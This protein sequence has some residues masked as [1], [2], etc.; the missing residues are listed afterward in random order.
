M[1]EHVLTIGLIG[2]GAFAQSQDMPNFTRHPQLKTKWCCDVNI[3]R[4]K[5]MA[6]EFLVPHATDDYRKVINDPEVDLI[7]ISTSHEVHQEIISAAAAKG[8]HVFCEKPMA[9]DETEAYHIIEAV[10]KNN[11]KLC[12]DLNRRQAPSMFALKKQW[13]KQIALPKHQPW[14]YIEMERKPLP[15]EQKSHLLI[16]IQ[17]E[18]AS[19]RILHFNPLKGGGE[20]LGE[21]V[22]WLD[23]ACWFFDPQMPV[24]ISRLGRLPLKPRR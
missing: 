21:T 22:H 15:E 12:V 3:E 20:I 23:L 10:R 14:R 4:A 6:R 9:L 5:E 7:K 17:D 18:S 2:C 19:Y 16:N 13:Q 24:G 8:I 1:S 11:I